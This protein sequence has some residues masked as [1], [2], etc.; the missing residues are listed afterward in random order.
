M[1]VMYV[2]ETISRVVV[3]SIKCWIQFETFENMS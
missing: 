3:T 2:L 1:E